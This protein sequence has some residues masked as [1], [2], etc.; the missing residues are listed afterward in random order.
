MNPIIPKTNST[1]GAGAPE[2]L[3]LG[4][5][6]S[7]RST[8]KLYLG[9]D[10]GV[11]EILGG[12]DA[13]S[14]TPQGLGTASAGTATAY[15]REDHVHP[16]PAF[17]GDVTND[18]TAVTVAKI[19]GSPVSASAPGSGQVLTWD[20][21]QWAPA[22]GTGGGGGGGANGLTYYLNLATAADAPTTGITGTPHQLDYVQPQGGMDHRR[23][24]FGT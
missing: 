3:Y 1:P 5:L 16:V 10:A 7:N 15:S 18:G 24:G 23:S 4:E 12:P 9:C 11:T 8:G 19:Q 22:Q 14:A 13:G 17:S 20:G 6:A 2:S 21:T